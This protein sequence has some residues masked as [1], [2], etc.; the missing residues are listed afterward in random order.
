MLE[1]EIGELLLTTRS[2]ELL[3]SRGWDGVEDSIFGS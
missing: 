1:I 3:W 2:R